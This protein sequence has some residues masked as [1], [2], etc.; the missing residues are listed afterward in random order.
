M[1]SLRIKDIQVTQRVLNRSEQIGSLVASIQA[2]ENI[3]KIILQ[4]HRGVIQ[5]WVGHHR[6]AAYHLAGREELFDG[7]YEL[8]EGQT[9]R[10]RFGTIE[11]LISWTLEP[12]HVPR[13]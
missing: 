3:E 6:L 5:V 7:E 10:H 4:R 11:D 2:D 12:D 13:G 8:I 1:A 9:G